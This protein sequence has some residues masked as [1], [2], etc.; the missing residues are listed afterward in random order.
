[1][2]PR[3]LADKVVKVMTGTGVGGEQEFHFE[4]IPRVRLCQILKLYNRWLDTSLAF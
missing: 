1:M 3:F 4:H 2:T